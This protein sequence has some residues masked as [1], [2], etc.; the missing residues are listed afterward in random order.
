[1]NP[2]R[3]ILLALC[4]LPAAGLAQITD[5]FST[6]DPAWIPNRYDPAGFESVVF[7][8]DSRL[9]LTIAGSDSAAN[10]PP[11]YSSAFYNIQGR[12]RPGGVAGAWTLSAQVYVAATFADTTALDPLV[13]TALWGHTGTSEAGGDYLIIGFTNAS[14]TDP[15]NAAAADRAFRFRVFD[16]EFG[17]YVDLGLPA[18]FVF[19]AWHTLSG[20]STGAT[21]EYFIDDTLVYSRATAA[22][23]DLLSAM[24]LGY[25]FGQTDGYA[26]YWDNVTAAA[27]PEPGAVTALFGLAALVLAGRR[28]RARQAGPGRVGAHPICPGPVTR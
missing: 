15:F 19:D 20:A 11:V 12:Q 10:R 5:T 21:F 26:V 16:A 13:R 4:V 25:N 8:S 27:I 9:R 17:D 24:V 2:L 14:P 1:M 7:D 3:P 28:H 6:I 23:D 22:W 18:G